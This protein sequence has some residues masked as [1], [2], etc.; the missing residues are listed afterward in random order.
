MVLGSLGAQITV[1]GGHHSDVDVA[2]GGRQAV[3]K[4][5]YRRPRLAPSGDNG[6]LGM[7]ARGAERHQ[8][9]RKGKWLA[10]GK[11]MTPLFYAALLTAGVFAF[12]PSRLLYQA[13][14]G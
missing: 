12:F 1:L 9:A 14:F 6:G 10:N 3:Y 8:R 2:Q 5:R 7:N 13:V 4:S 11:A